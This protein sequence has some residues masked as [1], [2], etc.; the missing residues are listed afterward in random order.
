[1][2]ATNCILLIVDIINTPII[3]DAVSSRYEPSQ[4]LEDAILICALVLELTFEQ[5]NFEMPVVR[6]LQS[7]MERRIVYQSFT[8]K[9]PCFSIPIA[10]ALDVDIGKRLRIAYHRISKL[11]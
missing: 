10:R 1:L 6:R 11:S 4:C 7:F 5:R 9:R 3:E 2:R 8:T